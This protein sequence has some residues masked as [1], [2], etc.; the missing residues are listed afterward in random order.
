MNKIRYDDLQLFTNEL[1]LN[2]PTWPE[3]AGQPTN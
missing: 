1:S 2:R 3:N